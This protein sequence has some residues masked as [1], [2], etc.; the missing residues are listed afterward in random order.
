MV[1]IEPSAELIKEGEALDRKENI[2]IQYFNE[3]AEATSLDQG[4]FDYVTVLRTWHWFKREKTLRKVRRLLKEGGTV[5]DSGFLSRR[6]IVLDTIQ[7][8]ESHL[9]EGTIKRAG[10]KAEEKQLIHRVPGEWSQE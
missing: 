7:L 10:S 5:M 3:Y 4:G 8:I 6:K 2:K 1:G 9:S